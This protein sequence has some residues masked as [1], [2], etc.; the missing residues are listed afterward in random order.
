[1]EANWQ[2]EGYELVLIEFERGLIE[3]RN[4]KPMR[5]PEG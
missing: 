2:A 3:L 1:L 4:S 5:Q